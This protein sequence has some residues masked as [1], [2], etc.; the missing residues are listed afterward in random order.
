MIRKRL[1]KRQ[2]GANRLDLTDLKKALKDRRC[3]ACHAVVVVAEGESSHWELLLDDD[4]ELIDILIDVTTQP[5]GLELTCRL[6]G[7]SSAGTLTIPKLGDEVIV[8][9]PSGKIDFSPAIVAILSSNDL[10]NGDQGPA[11]GRTLIVNS[12][13]LIH[14]GDGNA[15]PIPTM[16]EFKN[17]THPTSMGLSAKTLDPIPGVGVITGT[18]SLK[19]Y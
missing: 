1:K 11:L 10:P 16:A 17:H 14:Q 2:K 5:E 3:W 6:G 12:E 7:M 19:V 13:V 8:V 18:V 4:G 15:E 9:V